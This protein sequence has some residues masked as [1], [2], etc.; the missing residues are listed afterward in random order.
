[1][2][3][4]WF[5]LVL[6]AVMLV[7]CGTDSGSSQSTKSTVKVS[8]NRTTEE[9]GSSDST[10]TD[11]RQKDKTS[12]VASATANDEAFE[13]TG[14]LYENSIG[15]SLIVSSSFLPLKSS[16]SSFWTKTQSLRWLIWDQEAL[17]R[18]MVKLFKPQ[19][20]P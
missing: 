20:L 5:A 14:Y 17:I 9:K 4:R 8:D 6:T 7:G 3:R 16:V 11:N 18:L 19:P 12:A 13:K 15:D 10:V 1:M 2:K